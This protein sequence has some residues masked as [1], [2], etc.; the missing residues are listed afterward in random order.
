MQKLEELDK[1]FKDEEID[2]TSLF[3]ADEYVASWECGRCREG[4][5]KCSRY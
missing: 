1:G 4:N 3:F 2:I 5:A